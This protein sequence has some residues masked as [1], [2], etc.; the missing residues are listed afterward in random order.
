M[1]QKL[2]NIAA[3]TFLTCWALCGLTL[4]AGALGYVPAQETLM[5]VAEWADK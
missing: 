2:I 5:I 3:Y 4:L 1:K